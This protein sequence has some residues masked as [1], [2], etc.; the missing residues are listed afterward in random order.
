MGKK[1][2]S[3]TIVI[4]DVYIH[5]QVNKPGPLLHSK[6]EKLMAASTTTCQPHNE[7]L[8]GA[9]A[10]ASLVVVNLVH[11][12]TLILA[13]SSLPLRLLIFPSVK[14]SFWPLAA[15]FPLCL[16]QSPENRLLGI[17]FH[18]FVQGRLQ[19]HLFNAFV[20]WIHIR[21]CKLPLLL[22]VGPAGLGGQ[23]PHT[24]VSQVRCR[25]W[26]VGVVSED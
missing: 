7:S 17:L 19:T 22:V 2:V 15:Y 24:G 13:F 5:M 11:S 18:P 9:L 10:H 8:S 6:K 3:S 20:A 12:L 1:I 26:G 23:S 21:G 25:L 16:A 14:C 4:R